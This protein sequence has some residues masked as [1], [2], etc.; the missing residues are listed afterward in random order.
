MG[1]G[2]DGRAAEASNG[3]PPSDPNGC[4]IVNDEY[5]MWAVQLHA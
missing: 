4:I 1:L 5:G 3:R 2:S